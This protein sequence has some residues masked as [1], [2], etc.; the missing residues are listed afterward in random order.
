MKKM[1]LNLKS[2]FT[3]YIKLN[4]NNTKILIGLSLFIFINLYFYHQKETSIFCDCD[5]LKPVTEYALK[6]YETRKMSWSF[7][8]P[9]PH[10]FEGV[11]YASLL[12]MFKIGPLYT[13]GALEGGLKCTSFVDAM[14][15]KSG[16]ETPTRR[17]N[18]IYGTENF[19][20]LD[21]IEEYFE[22]VD[23]NDLKKDDIV[24]GYGNPGHI[25][26]I[27]DP[28][29]K[30]N[31]STNHIHGINIDYNYEVYKRIIFDENTKMYIGK[32]PKFLRYK[33]CKC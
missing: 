8:K 2:F 33:G 21:G 16:R 27:L 17:I 9:M 29:T 18:S 7:N 23:E 25:G 30:K 32:N 20:N 22:Y 26:F 31:I 11:R 15:R 14:L 13:H 24:I 28:K 6:E 4:K 5:N 10:E 1:I 12:G 19:Y 3:K